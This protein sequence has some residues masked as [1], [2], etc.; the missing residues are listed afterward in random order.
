MANEIKN[1]DVMCTTYGSGN[2]HR[3]GMV[4]RV[5]HDTVFR[6]RYTIGIIPQ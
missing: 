6:L 3:Q 4:K 1:K 2:S 5:P